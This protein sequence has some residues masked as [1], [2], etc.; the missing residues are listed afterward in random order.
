MLVMDGKFSILLS[1]VMD[2]TLTGFTFKSIQYPQI[3]HIT[4]INIIAVI[5]YHVFFTFIGCLIM[6]FIG[7]KKKDY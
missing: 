1:Q 4:T 3:I 6:A 5:I 7:R 2:F